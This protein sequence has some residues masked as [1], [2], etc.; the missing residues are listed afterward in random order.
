MN[1]ITTTEALAAPAAAT[2]AAAPRGAPAWRAPLVV[3]VLG[4][5]ACALAPDQLGLMTRIFITALLVLSLDLVVGV[6]G[7]ATLGHAALF[8]VGA[9]AAG[10][11]ALQV[12]PDPLIGLAVGIAA[13]AG[14]ALL[15]PPRQLDG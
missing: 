5:A 13:G 9:Y 4:A 10:I 7:L 11:F 2:A 6:A 3:L 1:T 8:G 15:P 12:H 14:L